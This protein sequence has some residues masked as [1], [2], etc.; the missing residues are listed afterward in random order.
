MLSNDTNR[1]A[2]PKRGPA[3]DWKEISRPPL[4]T[5]LV[6]LGAGLSLFAAAGGGVH[7]GSFV[8]PLI[9]TARRI[10]LAVLGVGLCVAG[11]C[12]RL[13]AANPR[14]TS[15]GILNGAPQASYAPGLNLAFCRNSKA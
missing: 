6:V 11:L 3:M 10:G 15:Q 1:G 7:L 12:L 8:L 2:R 13:D 9:D 5:V 14:Q 4:R